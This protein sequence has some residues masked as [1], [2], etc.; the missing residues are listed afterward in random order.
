MSQNN[1]NIMTILSENAHLMVGNVTS[2]LFT[3]GG[4]YEFTQGLFTLAALMLSCMVS[5]ATLYK[6]MKDFEKKG[7]KGDKGESGDKGEKG[8]KGDGG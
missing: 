6:I 7:S 5:G 2:W 4:I 3:I 1:L 8:E